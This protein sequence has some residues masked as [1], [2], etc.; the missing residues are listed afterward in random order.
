M[1]IT[2]KSTQCTQNKSNNIQVD[3]CGFVSVNG[4]KV[5]R[6]VGTSIEIYDRKSKNFAY[7]EKEAFLKHIINAKGV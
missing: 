5:F 1:M 6:I 2:M 4:V 3:S 7:V